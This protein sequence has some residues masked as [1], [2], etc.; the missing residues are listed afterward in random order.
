MNELVLLD[1]ALKHN[2]PA[3]L[4]D[5]TNTIRHGDVCLM[6]ESDPYL[7]EAKASKNLRDQ[8]RGVLFA[9]R[10]VRIVS[11]SAAKVLAPIPCH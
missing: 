1:S 2:V 9:S 5:L 7:I 6:G 3:L 8:L 4:V 10:I 11:P